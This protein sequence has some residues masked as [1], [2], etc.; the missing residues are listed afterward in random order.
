MKYARNIFRNNSISIYDFF[1]APASRDPCYLFSASCFSKC[2]L[3]IIALIPMKSLLSTKNSLNGYLMDCNS[4]F[5]P[6]GI[7]WQ[8]PSSKK[9]L[10]LDIIMTILIL[11]NKNTRYLVR[12]DRMPGGSVSLASYSD[13]GQDLRPLSAWRWLGMGNPWSAVSACSFPH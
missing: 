5:R 6:R 12:I 13:S 3:S 11:F 7:E 10:H 1:P 8:C 9:H 2:I 4:M